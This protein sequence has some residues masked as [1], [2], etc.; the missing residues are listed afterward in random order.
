MR[1][2]FFSAYEQPETSVT[3]WTGSAGR[4]ASEKYAAN[5]SSIQA[6][7]ILS[8][9]TTRRLVCKQPLY[10]RNPV[11]FWQVTS[12]ILLAAMLSVLMKG[13][14]EYGL[15]PSRVFFACAESHRPTPPPGHPRN[16]NQWVAGRGC[17]TQGNGEQFNPMT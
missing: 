9:R 4:P 13:A 16:D 14:P 2:Q 11:R 10:Y 17:P 5:S 1:E 7:S 15:V 3:L 12:L 8:A 6:Q